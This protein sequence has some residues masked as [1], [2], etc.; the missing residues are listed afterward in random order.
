MAEVMRAMARHELIARLEAA[1][2][3]EVGLD[4]AIHHFVC[5]QTSRRVLTDMR[6]FPMDVKGYTHS[7]DAALTLVPEGFQGFVGIC[8]NRLTGVWKN[9]KEPTIE[10]KH[11]VPAIALCVV[12]LRAGDTKP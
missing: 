10:A 2:E 4:I 1:T 7:I 3:P 12:A 5:A 9:K 11:N 8:G 6:G